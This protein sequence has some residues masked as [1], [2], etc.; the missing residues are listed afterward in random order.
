VDDTSLEFLRD[1]VVLTVGGR[2]RLRSGGAFELGISEDVLADRSPDVV[3]HVGWRW[4][5][6]R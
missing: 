4:P 5:A 2:L 3:F 6:F 1:A